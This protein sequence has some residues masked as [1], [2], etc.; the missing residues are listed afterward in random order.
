MR[1]LLSQLFAGSRGTRKA[2]RKTAARSSG[3]TP[4]R[5]R[6]VALL[7]AIISIAILTAV[8]V[9]FAFNSRVDLQLAANQRDELRA[10]YMAKSGI[11]LSRLLLKFQKQIDSSPIGGGA[12]GIPGL[13][14]IMK[15]LPP[16]LA[17]QLGVPAGGAGGADPMAGLMGGISIQLWKMARVD[18]HML[19]GMV[20]SDVEAPGKT[21][22]SPS[23]RKFGFDEEFPE[24]GADMQK[25][26]FGGFEGCFL[27][28]I[29]DEEEKLN[30]N[31]LDLGAL[32]GQAVVPRFLDLF[33]DKRFEF[34]YEKEDANKVKVPA[35]EVVVNL[36]DWIDSDNVQATMNLTG[37]GDPFQP[38]FSDENYLYDRYNPRYKAKN[39]AFDSVDELYMVHGV[40]DRF[41]AAFR[42]RL[43]V[44]PDINSKLNINTDDPMM[45]YMAVL[46][47]MDPNKPDPRIRDPIFVDQLIEKIRTARMMA[48]LPGLGMTV[49]DF[50]SVVQAAGIQVNQSIIN[51]QSVQSPV[52]DKSST[53]T[54][55]SVGEAGQVQKTITAVIRADG[56]LGKLMYWREE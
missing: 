4:K 17:Q 52:S 1:S 43:T 37:T 39:A 18:C 6:G 38:G 51:N 30:V 15:N 44:Y 7:I 34:L 27:A 22:S 9:D 55:K 53:F 25:K 56:N 5:Q 19:Q 2:T 35:A 11:G 31:K 54:I 13:G 21:G 14:D 32:A 26:S 45:L 42:D 48:I 24:L 40:N 23:S 10:Y 50:V 12:G 20:N 33:G 46:S 41:M 8:A 29:S 3:K 28:T 47:V 49:K 16:G 36:H